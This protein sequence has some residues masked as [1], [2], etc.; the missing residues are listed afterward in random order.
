MPWLIRLYRSDERF[1]RLAE[2]TKVG[3][4]HCLK[5][6]EAW[7]ERANH[8]PIATIER[9]YVKMFYRS[10]RPTP[11]TANAVLRVLRLLLQFAVDE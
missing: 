10:M 1:L 5:A 9:K 4:E 11:S 8:P 6:I 7:S 2:S 3:Y